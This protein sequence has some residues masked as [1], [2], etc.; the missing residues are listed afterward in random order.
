MGYKIPGFGGLVSHFHFAKQNFTP[1]ELHFSE[2]SL[3]KQTSPKALQKQETGLL[4]EVFL[5]K[6]KFFQSKVR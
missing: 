1:Q 6:V 3:A 4:D 2:T 5:R